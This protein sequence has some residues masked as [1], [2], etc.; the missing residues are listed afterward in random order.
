MLMPLLIANNKII[1]MVSR[2]NEFCKVGHIPEQ[3][4]RLLSQPNG[5]LKIDYKIS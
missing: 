4:H 1:D 2:L 5:S 3:K